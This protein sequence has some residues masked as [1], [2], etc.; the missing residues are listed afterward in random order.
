L[1]V[2]CV[3][4]V[5]L[6]GGRTRYGEMIVECGYVVG[7]R[8]GARV[9]VIVVFWLCARVFSYMYI[10]NIYIY[11]YIFFDNIGFFFDN[12]GWVE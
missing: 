12:L 6:R 8:V 9:F 11:I 7:V 4:V 1:V 2:W 3:Q 5:L 10:N